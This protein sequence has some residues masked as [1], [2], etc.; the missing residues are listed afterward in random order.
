M[1]LASRSI[2]ITQLD[3]DTVGFQPDG[4][5]PGQPLGVNTGDIITWN[6]RTNNELELQV[7]SI[8]LPPPAPPPGPTPQLFQKI[9]LKPGSASDAIFAVTQLN[10]TVIT[11]SCKKPTKQQHTIVVGPA[12]RPK[13]GGPRPKTGDRK[14][15][16][17]NPTHTDIPR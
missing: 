13:G 15:T 2:I 8:T 14:S 12:T 10:G 6:N 3:K 11:Y 16:R 5:K 4:G 1:A 17:P 7:L 9:K